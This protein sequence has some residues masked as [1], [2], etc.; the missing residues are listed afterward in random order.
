MRPDAQTEN[1]MHIVAATMTGIQDRF[2][3][4]YWNDL[5]CKGDGE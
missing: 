5:G 3:R 2:A 1:P 4:K